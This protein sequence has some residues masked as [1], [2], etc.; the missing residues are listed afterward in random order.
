MTETSDA[1]PAL[2][3]ASAPLVPDTRKYL[4]T[5]L[6]NRMVPTVFVPLRMI[7]LSEPGRLFPSPKSASACEA[8]GTPT[9][10]LLELSQ[11]PPATL[12]Q[13]L[14]ATAPLKIN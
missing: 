8:L 2:S 7:V 11:S 1:R 13:A 9:V 5:G 6:L 3:N 4:K 10:Q 12:F 14:S